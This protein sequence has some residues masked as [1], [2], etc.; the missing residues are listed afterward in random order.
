[1]LR[2]RDRTLMGEG[3]EGWERRDGDGDGDGGEGERRRK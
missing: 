1:M 2:Q 3:G